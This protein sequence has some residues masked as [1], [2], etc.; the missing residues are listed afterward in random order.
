MEAALTAAG[1]HDWDSL[2]AQ[3]DLAASVRPALAARLSLEIERSREMLA[4][5]DARWFA[6]RLRASE[7][8]RLLDCFRARV[9]FVDIETTGLGPGS[10]VTVVGL[11]A[12]AA[13]EGSRVR[14]FV[15]GANLDDFP[16]AAEPFD[17]WATYN[18][19]RFDVPFIER[20]FGARV[21]PSANVDLMYAARAAGLTGGLKAVE[22]ALGLTRPGE[23]EAVDGFEAVRL[24]H[25]WAGRGD[26]RS[27]RRLLLYNAMDVVNLAPLAGR[28]SAALAAERGLLLAG[29]NR[30]EADSR[31]EG[32]VEST[33]ELAMQAAGAI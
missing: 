6:E 19:R 10:E 9:A 24:W 13:P 15:K 33:V 4:K 2:L 31:L 18:G 21:R 28:V 29:E 23:I 17:V 30:G 20:R 32:E 22:R 8:W 7:H 12:P 5:G 11:H 16:A 27:L 14:L 1:I 25:A 3:P 26:A